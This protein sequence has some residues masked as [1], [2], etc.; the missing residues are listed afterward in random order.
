MASVYDGFVSRNLNRRFSRPIARLL[1]HTPLTPNQVS[2]LSIGVAAASFVTFIFGYHI[3]GALLAQ[4]SSITDGVDGDLARLKKMTSEFGGFMDSILDRY[5]DALIL[6]GLT[7]WAAGTTDSAVYAWVVGFAA[8]GGSFVVTYT[9]ARIVNAPRNLFDRGITSLASRDVRLF[10]LMVGALT[11]Q[12][13]VTLIVLASLT[14]AVVLLRVLHM[15]R[16][17]DNAEPTSVI[18]DDD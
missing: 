9:R 3:A 8:L 13:F 7:I 2:I 16:V 14:N 4:A 10:I 1:G 18:A 11:G 6:L 12:G 5:A 15:R 17:L